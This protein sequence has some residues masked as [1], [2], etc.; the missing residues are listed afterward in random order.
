MLTFL[1]KL[2]YQCFH[3]TGFSV[4]PG[5]ML[6]IQQRAIHR[7]L[8]RAARGRYQCDLLDTGLV[9]FQQFGCQTGSPVGV[10]SN[11]AVFYSYEHYYSCDRFR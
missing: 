1:N 6:G 2:A 4:P 9:G 5:L 11:R 10:V 8:E 7:H 3:F